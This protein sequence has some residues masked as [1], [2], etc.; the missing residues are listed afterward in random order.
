M[1]K[2]MKKNTITP[3]VHTLQHFY[4][5]Q[6]HRYRNIHIYL[7]PNYA[8]NG[9]RYP[10]IYMQDG[11]NLFNAATAFAREW[12]IDKSLNKLYAQKKAPCIVVGI[13]NGGQHR[14]DEYAPFQRGKMGGGNAD[15]Y[16]RFVTETLK[17]YIDHHY[18][19]LINRE[20]TGIAGS[21]M[22]G[23]LS[24]YAGVRYAHV[25]GKIGVLS[26]SLWYNPQVYEMAKQPT[27]WVSQ[28]YVSGSKTESKHMTSALEGVS[29]ALKTAG[30]HDW[31]L[32]VAIRDRG[33]HN[34][35][36]WGNE[37]KKMYQWWFEK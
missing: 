22:G 14:Q 15:N 28:W 7:P 20:N 34:E 26:P 25:F 37:F 32:Q 11:Q 30:H 8:Q 27:Q 31:A 18:N 6:L 33:R 9:Q 3:N 36:F 12:K 21:S 13:E 24:F 16:L 29:W 2:T 23:L 10:V 1:R 17:P 4:I 19:T 35:F 5:P